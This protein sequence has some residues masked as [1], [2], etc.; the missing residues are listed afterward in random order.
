M[1][2]TLDAKVVVQGLKKIKVFSLNE[3]FISYRKTKLKK[4]QFIESVRIPLLP[5]N[6]FN[7]VVVSS[8]RTDL[9]INSSYVKAISLTGS[10]HAGMSVASLSGKLVKKNVLAPKNKSL[11][12]LK[13]RKSLK[14]I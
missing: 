11:S 4:G 14:I 6:I 10:E 5:K 3:F 2:L 9:V 8:N 13:Q 7:V 1:L 12:F